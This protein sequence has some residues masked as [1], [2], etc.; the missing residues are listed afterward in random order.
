MVGTLTGARINVVIEAAD[1]PCLV[2][3]DRSQFDTAIVNIAVNAR[4]AMKGEG[5]LTIRVGHVIGMPAVR[6]H[7]FVPGEFITVALTDTGSGIAAERLDRIFEP[8]YTT[9]G[10]G[11]GTGLGLSQVF[12]FAKQSGGDI[13]VASD[14]GEGST[15][16]LYLPKALADDERAEPDAP[17]EVTSIGEG[18][19]VLVVEDNAEVGTFAT[20]ALTEL[21]Y[22]TVLAPDGASALVELGS[23]GERFDVVF[24]DVVMPG[25]SGIE[26]G[27]EIRRLYPRLP[28]VLTSG[29]S[30]V[31]AQNGTHGFE[32]LHKPYSID[33]LSRALRKVSDWREKVKA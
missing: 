13:L 22:N 8:F 31:L 18:A 17:E 7:P 21:G 30:T 15:F 20:Q 10:V 2:D 16:T 23:C 25:M 32:L 4:D 19:C 27:Q 14:E 29:Y 12:G 26:L 9:K 11:E 28:V 6:S 33:E 24:S 1:C 3:A 5:T